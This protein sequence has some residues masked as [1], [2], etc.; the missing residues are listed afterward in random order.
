MLHSLLHS[1]LARQASQ[2]IVA[3]SRRLRANNPCLGKFLLRPPAYQGT[4]QLRLP[5]SC[6][7]QECC[8]VQPLGGSV[9]Y[10]DGGAT[11]QWLRGLRIAQGGKTAER[12]SLL[13]VSEKIEAAG[14]AGTMLTMGTSAPTSSINFTAGKS[15]RTES[16][17]HG[18]AASP[19]GAFYFLIAMSI[20][21]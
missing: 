2:T 13:M 8:N 16:V 11:S 9:P 17:S 19:L 5:F 6:A 10:D 4:G 14:R 3:G 18:E 15:G 21:S 7:D 1:Y 12:E 20:A